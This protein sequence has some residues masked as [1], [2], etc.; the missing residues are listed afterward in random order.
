M[1]LTLTDLRDNVIICKS[2]GTCD[3]KF[4][5][6]NK[7]EKMYMDILEFMFNDI[8]EYILFYKIKFV[9]IVIKTKINRS[10]S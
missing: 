8:M 3:R 2:T 6:R 4:V 9:S 1:F 5:N 7:H 10:C